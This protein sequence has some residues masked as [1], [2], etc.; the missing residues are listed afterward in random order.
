[1]REHPEAVASLQTWLNIT[2]R[3]QWTTFTQ[4]KTA[5]PKADLVRVHSGSS[6]VV[7]NIAHNR[8]RLI[9][10][11]HFNNGRVFVLKFLTHKEYDRDQWKDEL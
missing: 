3:E 7:F 8:Y 4:L 9:A 10:G 11:V 5:F 1:M 6:V 2:K